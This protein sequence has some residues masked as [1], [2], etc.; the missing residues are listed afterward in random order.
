MAVTQDRANKIF[1]FSQEAY[2]EKIIKYHRIW[3]CKAVIM[4]MDMGL[5]S[6]LHDYQ[7]IDIFQI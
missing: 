2:L 3:E 6:L 4:P 7:A 5:T 1:C